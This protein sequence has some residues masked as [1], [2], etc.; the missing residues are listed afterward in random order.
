MGLM[1]DALISAEPID[2]DVLKKMLFDEDNLK[3]AFVLAHM[4]TEIAIHQIATAKLDESK[5]RV[6]EITLPG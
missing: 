2:W 6:V 4:I 3:H 5:Y 1:V